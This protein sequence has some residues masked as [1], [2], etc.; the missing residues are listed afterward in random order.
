MWSVPPVE[1]PPQDTEP[2]SAFSFATRSPIVLNG[3]SAGTTISSYSPVS[4]ASGVT[5]SRRDRRL[6]GQ[7]GAHHDQAADQDRVALALLAGD[8]LGEA[9][10]AAGAGDVLRPARPRRGPLSCSAVCIARAVWSQPPPGLAGAMISRLLISAW[11]GDGQRKG[12]RH[13]GG[14]QGPP[15]QA[16]EEQIDTCW[17]GSLPLFGP[18]SSDVVCGPDIPSVIIG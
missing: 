11:A 5:S 17:H 1:P 16:V 2:G 3:E 13:D 9:D 6:V 14:G 18:V 12:A 15:R 10:R 7:D 4:R 8:E